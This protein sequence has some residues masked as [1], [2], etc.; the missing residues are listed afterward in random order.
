MTVDKQV[1]LS[2]LQGPQVLKNFL[3]DDATHTVDSPMTIK[4]AE[5][6]RVWMTR[7]RNA[8]RKGH[9]ITGAGRLL[10]KLKSYAP[11]SS[12][13]QIGFVGNGRAGNVFLDPKSGSLI[14]FVLGRSDA[15]ERSE[16]AAS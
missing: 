12:I 6:V 4:V 3:R 7:Q 13:Q 15:S 10:L 16:Q 1:L 2:N 9:S 8:E 5:V 14:G 11:E